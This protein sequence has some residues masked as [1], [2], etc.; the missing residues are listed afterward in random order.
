V[1]AVKLVDFPVSVVVI[2]VCRSPWPSA[3][4][5]RH[6][7]QVTIG[8]TVD[9]RNRPPEISRISSAQGTRRQRSDPMVVTT[10]RLES[11]RCHKDPRRRTTPRGRRGAGAGYA[12]TSNS[13]SWAAFQPVLP[14][15]L[16]WTYWAVVPDGRVMV[17]V[18]PVA[19][20]NV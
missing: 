8:V 12:K 11:A 20:L 17:T 5:F 10:S 3:T 14:V 6:A 1:A 2:F 19:G 4:T 16:S 9:R 7:G 18:L 15:K 13:E